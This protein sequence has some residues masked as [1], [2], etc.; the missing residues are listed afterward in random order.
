MNRNKDM[1]IDKY[2]PTVNFITNILPI[3]NDNTFSNLPS[4]NFDQYRTLNNNTII[5]G[6][7]GNNKIPKKST[8]GA[9]N[10]RNGGNITPG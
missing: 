10:S 2:H 7:N 8:G 3:R 4:E 9:T 1:Y 6:N 5:G